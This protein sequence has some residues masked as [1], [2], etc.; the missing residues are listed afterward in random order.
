MLIA[1]A[2][3]RLTTDL[4]G[5]AFESVVA[6]TF[7]DDLQSQD[8]VRFDVFLTSNLPPKGAS[9]AWTR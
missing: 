3:A 4:E 6:K 7:F 5:P 9:R 8:N 1:G 2:L